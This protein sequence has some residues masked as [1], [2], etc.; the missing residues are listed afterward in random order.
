MGKSKK[1][2]GADKAD[3]KPVVFKRKN[4]SCSLQRPSRLGR[5]IPAPASAVNTVTTASTHLFFTYNA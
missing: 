1:G 3:E 4:S 2:M 5:Y